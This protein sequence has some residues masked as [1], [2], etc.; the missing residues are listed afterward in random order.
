MRYNGKELQLDLNDKL[1][2]RQQ[3]A[4]VD[5]LFDR[6]ELHSIIRNEFFNDEN[7]LDSGLVDAAI[8]RLLL[9]DGIDLNAETLQRERER[10]IYRIIKDI[11]QTDK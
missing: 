4:D 5:C 7:K 10:M 6:A 11:V 3:I 2:L 1:I 8:A 9:L